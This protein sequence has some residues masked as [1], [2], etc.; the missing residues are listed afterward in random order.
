MD[1]DFIPFF[2]STFNPHPG[3]GVDVQAILLAEKSYLVK[4]RNS[5]AR[6]LSFKNKGVIPHAVCLRPAI[7]ASFLHTLVCQLLE[8]GKYQKLSS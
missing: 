8:G 3:L 1:P 6:M 7:F 4:G 2:P 5:S